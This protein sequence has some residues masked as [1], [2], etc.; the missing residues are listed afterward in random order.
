MA[1]WS[2]RT[3]IWSKQGGTPVSV[4]PPLRDSDRDPL[5]PVSRF[6]PQTV[7]RRGTKPGLRDLTNRNLRSAPVPVTR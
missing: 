1:P 3:R 4:W 6:D 7:R 2:L 5:V